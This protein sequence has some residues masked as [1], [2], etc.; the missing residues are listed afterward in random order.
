MSFVFISSGTERHG[1]TV[2]IWQMM[3]MT[4]PTMSRRFGVEIEFLSTITISQVLDSLRAAGIEVESMGYSHR[5]TPHWKVV[6]DGSCG[7]ELVSPVL[8]GEAGIEEVRR[9][10]TALEAQCL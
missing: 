6:H 4:T 9:A 3:T 7:Y 8:E 5:T 2:L 1:L 10:A